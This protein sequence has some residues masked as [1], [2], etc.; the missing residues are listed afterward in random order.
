[1][2]SRCL[3]LSNK[4]LGNKFEQ[5]VTDYLSA[6]KFWVHRLVQNQSGQPADIIAARNG[7]A[8]L[9]DCKACTTPYFDLSRIELNQE[10]AMKKWRDCRNGEGLF[11]IGFDENIY[12]LKLSAFSKTRLNKITELFCKL[13]GN[14]IEDWV[15]LC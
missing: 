6:H 13:N 5:T 7:K 15:K 12:M 4:L 9:I 1:M 14:L 10:L 8:Y 3:T 11:C 2:G